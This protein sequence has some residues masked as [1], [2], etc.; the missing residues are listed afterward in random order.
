MVLFVDLLPDRARV[1][2][3][4]DGVGVLVF[5]VVEVE[6]VLQPHLPPG[7]CILPA[8]KQAVS[9]IGP[10]EA[11]GVLHVVLI[12]ETDDVPVVVESEGM[13]D[14]DHPVLGVAV[15]RRI[16]AASE[17]EQIGKIFDLQPAQQAGE[18]AVAL[19]QRG[20]EAARMPVHEAAPAQVV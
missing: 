10:V 11:L 15:L 20:D 8:E 5:P 6:I 19:D 17:E 13:D 18:M 4:E 2:W 9:A 1:V 7:Q 16:R 14:A 12:A 3:R